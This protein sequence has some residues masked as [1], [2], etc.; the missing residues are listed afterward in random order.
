MIGQ[1]G[2]RLAAKLET[3]LQ[4][5]RAA[6]REGRFD[7]LADL[8]PRFDRLMATQADAIPPARAVKL[9]AM[10]GENARLL[11]AALAGLAEARQMRRGAHGTRL[12]TYDATGR[13]SSPAARGQALARR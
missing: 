11:Q 8:L 7:A 2:E 6:L 12:S 9:Q 4:D 5:Q 13:L 10:A 1:N 3:L